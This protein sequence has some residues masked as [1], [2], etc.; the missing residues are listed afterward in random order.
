M[1]QLTGIA[2]FAS[3]STLW[4]LASIAQGASYYVSNQGNDA[5]SGTRPSQAFLTVSRGVEALSGGDSLYFRAGDSWQLTKPIVVTQSGTADNPVTIGAYDVNADGSTIHENV[6]ERPVLD[7][8]WAV[9]TPGDWVGL[10]DVRAKHIRIQDLRIVN[11]GGLGI[12][13]VSTSHGAV[14][15]VQINKTY[16]H[17]ILSNL[18][19]NIIIEGCG[20]TAFDQ[21]WK[22]NG[23]RYWSSGISFKAGSGFQV[24]RCTVSKGW[25][26]G[27]SAFYGANDIIL[28]KN[29]L[30][31][32]RA[33][34]IYINSAYDVEIRDNMVLGTSNSDY[35]RFGENTWVGA[36][37]AMGN[38]SYQ[39]QSSGGRLDDAVEVHNVTVA[40]NLVAA[41]ATGL[42]FWEEKEDTVFKNIRVLH[43]TFV[44]NRSQIRGSARPF[45]ESIFENNIFL[46]ISANTEDARNRRFDGASWKANYWS[47]GSPGEPIADIGD[48]YSGIALH[49]MDGWQEL[50]N[51]ADASWRD[52]QPLPESSTNSAGVFSPWLTADYNGRLRSDPPD[53]GA[54]VSDSETLPLGRPKSPDNVR[55]IF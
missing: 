20:V 23:L 44:E 43:N 4:C 10:I 22:D 34:G 5:S 38:E 15:N 39:Y 1:S 51:L 42:A 27:I 54:L 37:I 48:V 26:E 25:G 7:G 45:L 28:E 17:G 2:R 14:R 52:F 19:S 53:M 33:V 35:H 9:P 55:L 36:G 30:F 3:F 41:T 8:G 47:H 50:W 12:Q 16:Y 21:G 13:F 11:S 32:A 18:S 6:Q 49:R 29:I 31:G 40:N 46:S 24:R